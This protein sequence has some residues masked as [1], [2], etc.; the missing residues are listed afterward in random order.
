MPSTRD[1][2]VTLLQNIGSRREIERYLKEFSSV[3]RSRFAVIKVDGAVLQGQLDELGAALS[4]LHTIGLCPVV[5]HGAGPQ[6]RQALAE[7]SP[8]SAVG[9]GLHATTSET[10][11][12]VRR[13]FRQVNLEL[14]SALEQRGTPVRPIT[15][16]VFEA[17]PV[18]RAE[19]GLVGAVR[20][21]HL[22]AVH[23]AIAAG[24]VP[25]LTP[26]GETAGGQILDVD[27]DVATRALAHA[28][29]PSK[30]VLLTR[31]GGLRD[32]RERLIEAIN[33]VEDYD[34]LSAETWFDG[35]MRRTLTG[36]AELLAG[37]PA[38]SSVSITSPDRLVRELFTHRGAGTF[39]RQGEAVRSFDR[40]EDTET[41]RL[42]AL[43]E[44]AFARPLSDDYF[45]RKLPHR[46]YLVDSYRAAAII[47]R[48]G[49][50]PYLDKFAVT[51]A[52]QGA[53][54]GASLWRRI[55]GDYPT[56][57]WRSRSDN[58][59]NPWY[60][61]NADGSVRRPP[62]IVF[63]Y[64]VEGFI[65][66]EECVGLALAMSPTLGTGGLAEDRSP[67]AATAI[68]KEGQP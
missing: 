39:I 50:T 51:R 45:A 17:E 9:D 46:I 41:D 1:I 65:A 30:V 40:F 49:V 21:V 16:G 2:V 54:L 22:D 13:V 42:R 33:L 5:L 3:D 58:P 56:L 20:A 38:S 63:W 57:F 31:S 18:A 34:D 24:Q 12:I 32:G 36:I 4:F 6:I 15:A 44:H 48:E 64:G 25:I 29:Q 66:I 55:R 19:R 8:D 11:S 53:G 59:I 7:Q 67:A 28:I 23:A 35:D 43:I 60:F 10:L 26:L 37:L 52:A 62:W 68:H 61:A 14:A 47:T 27:A